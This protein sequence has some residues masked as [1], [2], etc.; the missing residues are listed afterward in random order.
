MISKGK[1]LTASGKNIL[2]GHKFQEGN[3][4]KGLS[5]AKPRGIFPNSYA[6]YIIRDVRENP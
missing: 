5:T 4:N 1:I 6:V 3:V 2:T